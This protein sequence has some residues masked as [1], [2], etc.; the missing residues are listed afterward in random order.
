MEEIKTEIKEEYSTDKNAISKF[1]SDSIKGL[2]EGDATNYRYKLDDRLAIFVGWS[3]GYGSEKRDDVIQ[4]KEDPNWAINVG[5]KVW[6]SDD[7]WTDYDYLNYPYYDNG[8]VVDTGRSIV[9]NEDIDALAD[10]ILADYNDIKDFDI[11]ENGR[12]IPEDEEE[13]IEGTTYVVHSDVDENNIKKEF[14]NKEDAIEYAK[15]NRNDETWVD[16]VT[17]NLDTNEEE[18]ETIWTYN[19]DSDEDHD[20][21][22]VEQ[23][24]E[25]SLKESKGELS[26]ASIFDILG[27]EE[28][29]REENKHL[30]SQ[31]RELAANHNINNIWLKSD[32]GIY[33]NGKVLAETED[34]VA[35]ESPI[36]ESEFSKNLQESSDYSYDTI[37]SQFSNK[38]FSNKLLLQKVYNGL[39][40]G[41]IS[42]EQ[43][44]EL[45][46]E[47]KSRVEESLNESKNIDIRPLNGNWVEWKVVRDGKKYS[48]VAKV[49]SEPSE[50][51]IRKGNVS[52]FEAKEDGKD[53]ANFDRGWDIKPSAEKKSLINEIIKKLE[54]YGKSDALKEALEES[55]WNTDEDTESV[56]H[57]SEEEIKGLYDKFEIKED[58]TITDAYY[59]DGKLHVIISNEKG[60]TT[61]YQP[62]GDESLKESKQLK[63]EV[64][65]EAYEIADEINNRFEGSNYVSWEDFNDAFT[66][67]CKNILGIDFTELDPDGSF[68]LIELESDVRGI[69]ALKG[70][71]TEWEGENE[72][73]LKNIGIE[74]SN[75]SLK[76]NAEEKLPSKVYIH[77]AYANGDYDDFE[78]DT[79]EEAIKFAKLYRGDDV[80]Y[81]DVYVDTEDDYETI[82]DW[83]VEEL[84]ESCKP[85]K[86]HP[87][88]LKEGMSNNLEIV[89]RFKDLRDTWRKHAILHRL[90]DDSYI[91][92]LGFDGNQWAQGRYDYKTAEDAEKA[93]KADYQVKEI[94]EGIVP[95]MHKVLVD[96]ALVEIDDDNLLDMLMNRLEYWGPN[97]LDRELYSQMYESYVDGG[98]FESG[99]FDPMY[100]VDNDWVNNCDVI[101]PGDD[102]YDKV[103]ECYKNE[104]L[105][106]IST[107]DAGYDYIEAATE[108]NGKTYFLCRW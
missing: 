54:E 80:D 1:L 5:I 30:L 45:T 104:G 50:F 16:K 6:T 14:D 11:A 18:T 4:D 73:G 49:F 38:E 17:Y 10:S 108:R 97:D 67:A 102:Y 27:I 77:I 56:K 51:G 20:Q 81:I 47:I 32:V 92:A 64:S 78:R 105:G 76:E 65:N 74:S 42:R 22:A 82:W 46:N 13:E 69:L 99:K 24:F 23:E 89:K 101:G 36:S 37:K 29:N 41:E 88:K 68:D 39:T 8:D 86:R 28:E 40:R 103:L 2:Q 94:A 93:L 7:F 35:I 59:E 106:D 44:R 84:E 66:K 19:S 21:R 57:L 58:E 43:F 90:S 79:K 60:E 95:K 87:N 15:D 91:I 70:W 61:D 55:I 34:L 96:E 9:P 3:E 100:I 26:D 85:K 62:E 63:E 83:S 53:I 33:T 12:I 98:V 48:G 71:E 75:E 31:F 25:E 52:K 72:G 107:E